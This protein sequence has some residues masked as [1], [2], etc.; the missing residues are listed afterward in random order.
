MILMAGVTRRAQHAGVEKFC[1]VMPPDAQSIGL[2]MKSLLKQAAD[3]TQ[4]ADE[5]GKVGARCE[6]VEKA[7]AIVS[8]YRFQARAGHRPAP[9]QAWKCSFSPETLVGSNRAHDRPY[10]Y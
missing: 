4:A 3:E 9:T 1:R 8:T 7:S 2:D 10:G 5:V 6:G